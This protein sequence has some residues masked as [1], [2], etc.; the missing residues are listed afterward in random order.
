MDDRRDRTS[1][2]LASSKEAFRGFGVSRRKGGELAEPSQR[3]PTVRVET[4]KSVY[5]PGDFLTCQ[6][7]VKLNDCDSL[8]AL[9]ASVVWL[10]EGKGSVDI[11]VHFFERKE[12]FSLSD[13]I[14]A[15]PMRISTV[16]PSSPLSY[17]GEILTIRWAVRIRL[18]PAGGSQLTSDHFFELGDVKTFA[19]ENGDKSEEE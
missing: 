8:A 3:P 10:T 13:E 4:D 12:K 17:S 15:A 6:F 2:K 11:G 9:E 14:L 19:V 1:E 7:S 5:Q 18:F 16:L